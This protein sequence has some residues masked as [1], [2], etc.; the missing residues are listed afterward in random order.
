MNKYRT[1]KLKIKELGF[2]GFAIFLFEKRY[3]IKLPLTSKLRWNYEK[4]SEI[5]FW[6]SYF[7]TK[8]LRWA[9]SYYQSFDPSLPLQEE[10][11]RL[12]PLD[13]NTVN[14]L[15]VGAGPLTYLGKV[16]KN[17]IINITAVDPLADEYN[18]LFKK[19]NISPIL[20]TKK[21]AAEKLSCTYQKDTFDLVFARNCIDHSWSPE[22]AILEMIKVVKKDCFV[23]MIH[24]PNEAITENYQG[25]HQWNF[26]SESGNFII[27]SKNKVINFSQKYVKICNVSCRDEVGSDG[28]WLYTEIQKL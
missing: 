18:K 14:I 20:R 7:K 24:R 28:E 2:S 11:V 15:D 26:S 12:L 19:Y 21:M 13:K 6:D 22:K 5:N 27:S 8:G 4:S 9:D 17:L 10:V 3:K 25:L 16:Y 23:L 1:I